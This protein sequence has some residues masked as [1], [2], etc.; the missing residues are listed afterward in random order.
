[1]S[2]T[3]GPDE[4]VPS[5]LELGEGARWVD[6]H[7]V[8]VDILAGNLYRAE[9][10]RP[11]PA[12]LLASTSPLPL[13]AVAPVASAPN[14]W[15]AAVGTGIALLHP[16][17]KLSWLGRPADGGVP[18][19]MNDGACDS[20]GRFWAT[21]MGWNAEPGAGSLLLV[22]HDGTI[23]TQVEG[24]TVPNGPAFSADGSIMYLA[25]SARGLVFRYDLDQ[26]GH[27]AERT[28]FL[29]VEDGQP[30]GMTVDDEDGLWVA[31]WG[32]GQ[33]RHYDHD[34]QLVDSFTV[35]ANQPTSPCLAAS[36][37]FVTT[38]LHGL[39]RADA[40][41]SGAIFAFDVAATAPPA[42][43]YVHRT[44]QRHST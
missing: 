15:V 32:A 2:H 26:D 36:R 17:T 21:C 38:A 35:P 18:R 29:E 10:D 8:F 1:M 39:D 12:Q 3:P 23:S 44:G 37:L 30:D 6:N 41:M 33:V 42:T 19:R 27:L 4:W 14:T 9:V 13:G 40:G 7:L 20:R 22:E 16:D 25:D 11:G 24:L 34:G 5:R 28:V 31:V 43:A